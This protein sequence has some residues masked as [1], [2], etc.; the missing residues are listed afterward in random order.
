MPSTKRKLSQHDLVREEFKHPESYVESYA[1]RTADAHF[2]NTR[3]QRVAELT[4]DVQSGRVLSLG[5]GPCMVGHQ[6]KSK[7]VEFDGLD[8]SA[9]TITFC[10]QRFR[11]YPNCHFILG[12][13]EHVP[14]PD[15]RYDLVLCLGT[16]EYVEDPESAVREMARV[17]APGGRVVISMHNRFSPYR[18]WLRHGYWK[19]ANRWNRL[20]S[21]EKG[22]NSA[23]DEKPRA[24][25]QLLSQH[26][27]AGIARKYGLEIADVI[28]FDFNLL[29]PPLDIYFPSLA[30]GIAERLEG[31]CRSRLRYLG[32]AYLLCAVRHAERA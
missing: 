18:L 30:V 29:L 19:V 28:Y 5:C 7:T 21:R 26:K 16:L 17:V 31:L 20:R 3:L 27:L 6:F 8:I 15:Q 4:G 23:S 10:R 14:C 25:L 11:Q 12:E 24:K 22:R 32:S 9:E 13:V 1:G 2:F